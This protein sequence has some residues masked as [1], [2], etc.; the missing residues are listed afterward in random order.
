MEGLIQLMEI[1]IIKYLIGRKER[2]TLVK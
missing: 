2:S 1:S